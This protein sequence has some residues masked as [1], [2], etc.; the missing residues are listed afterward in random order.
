MLFKSVLSAAA[1]AFACAVHG[2]EFPNKPIRMIVPFAPG[3][4]MDVSTRA[5]SGPLQEALGQSVIVE[6]R[7]GGGGNI[8]TDAVARAA[9]DG[10]TLL[11]IG[12]HSTIAPALYSKLSYDIVKDFAP[13]TN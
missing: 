12:D 9:P 3:G 1:L 13:I 7:P 10:F 4:V 11:V 8:G 5:V 2:Q 6:N